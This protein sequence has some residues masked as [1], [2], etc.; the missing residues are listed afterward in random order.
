MPVDAHLPTAPEGAGTPVGAAMA[1][2]KFLDQLPRDSGLLGVTCG[3]RRDGG[4]AQVIAVMSTL[5]YAAGTGIPYFHTPFDRLMHSD[6][7]DDYPGRWERFFNLGQ[8]EAAI[9]EGV[10]VMTQAAYLAAGRPAGVIVSV[11]HCHPVVQ[12]DGTADA[13]TPALRESFR[14]K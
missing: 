8:G 5:A 12:R 9:P 3:G 7:K 10:P 1:L 6:G 4:G 14:A 11:P 13:Y 2:P